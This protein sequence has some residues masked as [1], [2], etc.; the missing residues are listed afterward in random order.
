MIDLASS[1]SR[2]GH[3]IT[4][5]R[6]ARADVKWWIDFPPS[7]NGVEM[8]QEDLAIASELSLFTDASNTGMGGVFQNKWFSAQWPPH[9]AGDN[10]STNFQ[11]FFAIFTALTM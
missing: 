5:N 8:F 6:E 10:C 11:E 3:H 4:L 7:W 2:L 9:M 1:V